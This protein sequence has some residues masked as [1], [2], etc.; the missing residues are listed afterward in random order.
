MAKRKWTF[1]VKP[2]PRCKGYNTEAT[3]TDGRRG[4]QYRRCRMAVCR[5]RYSVRGQAIERPRPFVCPQCGNAY[6]RQRALTRHID[7][8]HGGN[9]NDRTDDESQN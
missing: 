5:K 4:I 2:C 8:K 7:S 1:P 9:D 3:R 6:E